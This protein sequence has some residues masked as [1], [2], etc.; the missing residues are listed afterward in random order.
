MTDQAQQPWQWLHDATIHD[1][2][3]DWK[4]GTLVIKL[5]VG[6][7]QQGTVHLK[8]SN[9]SFLECPRRF[10]WGESI[11]IN[12]IRGPIHTPRGE[13][14]EIEIQSGDILVMVAS[15]FTASDVMD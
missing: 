2:H 10:P 15:S 4:S 12:D 3:L 14:L 6:R 9:L 1:L 5:R 8:G 11:S 13:R 7:P